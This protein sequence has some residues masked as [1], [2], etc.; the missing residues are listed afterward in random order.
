[1]KDVKKERL[2]ELLADQAIFGLSEEELLELQQFKTQFPEWEKDVS[3]E[4]TAASINLRNLDISKELPANLRANILA[5]AE[6][7]FSQTENTQ[8]VLSS[9]PKTR[10]TINTERAEINER[11]VEYKPKRQF[12]QSLGWAVAAAACIALAINVWT[13]RFQPQPEVAKNPQIVQ[14]PTPELSEAQKRE[15]F[16]ASAKDVIQ[17]IWTEANPKQPKNISGDLVWSNS[18]QKG[19]MRFRG[20]PAN[21]PNKETYQLWIVDEAQNPKTPI[22]GGVF[23]V[24]ANGEVVIPIEAQIKV[25]NPK[26]F[27]VTK[28][29]PGGVVVSKQEE[30]MAVAKI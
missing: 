2:F 3:F 9:T 28:E 19:Y 15:Q 16:L 17:T 12:W 4:L 7:F 26:M 24:N 25:K 13:T 22:S 14:T 11:N 27:A 21:D 29:K 23:D 18:A 6:E 5:D 30:V 1:M 8:N 20:L 10:E